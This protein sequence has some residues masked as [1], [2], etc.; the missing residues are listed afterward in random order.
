LALACCLAARPAAAQDAVTAA[1]IHQI[2]CHVMTVPDV[3]AAIRAG[4]GPLLVVSGR[5]LG[6]LRMP[7]APCPARTA[8]PRGVTEFRI[9]AAHTAPQLYGER[10]R[11]G[12]VL[13]DLPPAPRN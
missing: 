10:G 7:A 2:T 6:P 8:L 5:V 13:V 12:A 1:D 3:A 9:V 4:A 11:N